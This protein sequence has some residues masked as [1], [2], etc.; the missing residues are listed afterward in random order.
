MAV[1]AGIHS[2]VAAKIAP[3]G[4]HTPPATATLPSAPEYQFFADDAETSPPAA[5][6]QYS[7]A[8]KQPVDLAEQPALR[9][10]PTG[11][12]INLSAPLRAG[13]FILNEV[14][15]VLTADDMI[16]V[17]SKSFIEASF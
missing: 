7:F 8:P 12:D 13:T 4:T 10:N 1:N 6:V 5:A 15:F 16:K 2:S 3:E 14:S 11:R 17:E 9:L